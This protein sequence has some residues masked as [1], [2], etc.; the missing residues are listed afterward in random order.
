MNSVKKLIILSTIFLSTFSKEL[1]STED[2]YVIL[3]KLSR[4]TEKEMHNAKCFVKSNINFDNY[5][6]YLPTFR[7]AWLN[8]D[9]SNDFYLQRRKQV[10]MFSIV[11]RL[12]DIATQGVYLNEKYA[13]KCLFQIDVEYRDLHGRQQIFPAVRWSFDRSLF[14]SI[15]WK[16]VDPRDFDR[17]AIDYTFNKNLSDWYADEPPFPR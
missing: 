15:D 12:A 7:Q 2:P 13:D 9:F 11:K 6:S 8:R 10:F 4:I 1:G 17:I 3:M 14:N 16:K 5:V